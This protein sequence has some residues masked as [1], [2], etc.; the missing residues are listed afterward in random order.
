MSFAQS[1]LSSSPTRAI[2]PRA[3]PPARPRWLVFALSRREGGICVRSCF[4]IRP[5]AGRINVSLLAARSQSVL[6]HQGCSRAIPS[7]EQSGT[8]FARRQPRARRAQEARF[9]RGVRSSRR[10]ATSAWQASNKK[11][12]SLSLPEVDVT[13]RRAPEFRVSCP[14]LG[15]SR[16]TAGSLQRV[17]TSV[18]PISLSL[19]RG[20]VCFNEGARLSV[21]VVSA[22]LVG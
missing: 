15:G 20:I 11:R 14:D 1:A 6:R 18:G 12:V 5:I 19:H 21:C 22:K 9:D 7:I 16:A 10:V 4:G 2:S 8:A 13:S 17:P 3:F